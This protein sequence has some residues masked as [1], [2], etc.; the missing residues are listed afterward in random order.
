M[1][2][3]TKRGGY[4]Y[5]RRS[6]RKSRKSNILEKIYPVSPYKPKYLHVVKK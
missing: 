2:K 1:K 5:S 6:T 3:Q 4:T